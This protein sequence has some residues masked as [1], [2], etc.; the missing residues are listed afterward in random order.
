MV[1]DTGLKI[2]KE[3]EVEERVARLTEVLSSTAYGMSTT[4]GEINIKIK[5]GQLVKLNVPGDKLHAAVKNYGPLL[6]V[7]FGNDDPD[8]IYANTGGNRTKWEKYFEQYIAIVHTIC[9]TEKTKLTNQQLSELQED[10]EAFGDLWVTML[11]SVNIG[12]YFHYMFAGHVVEMLR[13]WGNLSKYSNQGWE[14]LNGYMKSA[15]HRISQ[16]DGS[17]NKV[18]SRLINFIRSLCLRRLGYRLDGDINKAATGGWFANLVATQLK[19]N[20]DERKRLRR[21]EVNP[22]H[23]R[24]E[25][26]NGP[27]DR[28][29]QAEELNNNAADDPAEG[30]AGEVD[31][32][33]VG[34]V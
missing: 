2:W 15:I 30:T 20:K 6:D 8:K 22:T 1:Q 25:E 10:I 28:I 31:W 24:V 17:A 19:E 5:N 29:D 12:N 26:G 27:Q 11:P 4:G 7:V 18:R 13:K 14:A 23:A 3:D 34:T 33:G 32:D 9:R 21:E 16:R